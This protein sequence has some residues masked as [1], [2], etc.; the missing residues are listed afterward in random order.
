V[1][2]RDIDRK[3]RLTAAALGA[4]TRKDLAA[5][6]RRANPAT[7]FDVDRANKW[8]Q[9]RARPRELGIYED[10]AKLLDLGRSGQWIADCD[11]NAF[12][13]AVCARHGCEREALEQSGQEIPRR[14]AATHGADQQPDAT[15]AGKFVSYSHAGSPHFLGRIIGGE[16]SIRFDPRQKRFTAIYGQNLPTGIAH[17]YGSVVGTQRTLN[18]ELRLPEA[19]L[20]WTVCLFRPPTMPASLLAGQM[21]GVAFLSSETEI[22]TTRILFV[23]VPETL[24]RLSTDAY[25]PADR[26]PAADLAALGMPLGDPAEADRRIA[27]F[28][29]AGHD[30]GMDRI[31]ADQYASLTEFFDYNWLTQVAPSGRGARPAV[32]RVST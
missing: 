15:L 31:T 30:R 1:S 6:F 12:I 23:R 8:L 11:V 20:L 3:L 7:T 28:L 19:N 13:D 18:I 29:M 22:N 26:S 14:P 21:T 16:L 5:A 25:L 9:G 24:T 32:P 27:A 2:G 10:W 17:V 4:V